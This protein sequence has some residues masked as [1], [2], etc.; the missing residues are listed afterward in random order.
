M[1]DLKNKIIFILIPKTG[2]QSIENYFL[3]INDLSNKDKA[4]LFL[5]KNSHESNMSRA[6]AHLTLEMYEK[7]YFGGEIPEDFKIFS[8][9]RNPHNRFVSESKYRKF[10]FGFIKFRL[11]MTLLIFIYKRYGKKVN[12]FRDIYDHLIPQI[13]YLEGNARNRINILRLENLNSEFERLVLSWGLPNHKL[14][15]INKSA[16]SVKR[17]NH[18]SPDIL[19]FINNEYKEDFNEFNYDMGLFKQ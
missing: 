11:P 8:V 6:N 17:S 15:H 18:L 9:V 3:R 16:S 14:K 10:R 13:K 2:G 4:S 1:I 7:Y 12:I 19:K 5:F